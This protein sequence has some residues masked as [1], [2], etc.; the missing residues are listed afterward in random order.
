MK[1]YRVYTRSEVICSYDIKADSEEEANA[2]FYDYEDIID[3]K[4]ELSDW[5]LDSNEEII[6]TEVLEAQNA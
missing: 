2:K 3:E 5:S 1:V 6:K 4:H